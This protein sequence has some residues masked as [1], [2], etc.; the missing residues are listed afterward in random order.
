MPAA[1]KI[2]AERGPAAVVG[3]LDGFASR[4]IPQVGVGPVASVEDVHVAARRV[5][6]RSGSAGP[7]GPE[8]AA[9]HALADV[10]V[11][12]GNLLVA[13]GA[14]NRCRGCPRW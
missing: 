9:E 7:E 6:R 11:T 10:A 3:D 5:Q 12:V 14:L 4:Q 8:R 2:D 13:A 1:G